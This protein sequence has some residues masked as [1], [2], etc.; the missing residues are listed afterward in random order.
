MIRDLFQSLTRA[1][2]LGMNGRNA[3]YVM[4]CNPRHLYPLADNKVL[5]K[6]LAQVHG[7]PIP[8]VYCLLEHTGDLRHLS[9]HLN[10]R[11]QFVVKPARGSGGSGI[12]LVYDR[13]EDVFLTKDA[14]EISQAELAYRISDILSGI[15]SLGG[16]EDTAIVE[17]LVQPDEIFS[18]IMV[19][20]VPDVRIIV[21]HGTPVMAMVRLPTRE[22]G[23]KAN[24]HQGAV[25]AGIDLKTGL[26]TTAV[27]KSMVITHHPDT[28]NPIRFVPVPY[29]N[30]ILQTASR[31]FDMTGLSYLGVDMVIDR[32][33]GPVLLEINIRPGLGI[34][35]ANQRGL[36]KRLEQIDALPEDLLSDPKA[37]V[38]WA[39]EH[40]GDQ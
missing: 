33:V 19:R 39:K 40:L 17:A 9:R 6:K 2:V 31:S 16:M 12:I 20:G 35:I 29:W 34:Q 18:H 37:R 25:G 8:E 10:G 3:E 21:Y 27:H 24:L 38:D 14:E 15:Y 5:T 4:P 26:T 28:K 23:G 13:R 11:R 30:L 32:T 22:S 7:I 36:R 1:G